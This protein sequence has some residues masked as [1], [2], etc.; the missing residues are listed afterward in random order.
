[1]KRLKVIL[2]LLAILGMQDSLYAEDRLIKVEV[3]AKKKKSEVKDKSD[4]LYRDWRTFDTRT[5][6]EITDFKSV[7]RVEN[8]SSYGCD[9]TRKVESTG[10]F[11]TKKIG[12]RW[13]VVDPDGYA[14]VYTLVN[15]VTIPKGEQS[16]KAFSEKYRS[17]KDW[18]AQTS[19]ILKS[20]GFDGAG[21]WSDTEQI[22]EYNKSA[23][24]PLAYCVT[25]RLMAGYGKKRGGTYQLPGNI[26]YPNQCIFVFDPEFEEYCNEQ[27]AELVKYKDDKNLFGYFSDN[28]LPISRNNLEGYLKL[29]NPNDPGRLAAE[30]YLRNKGIKKEQVTPEHG[31]EF[32]GIVADKYYSIVSSAIKK[33]DPNHMYIGSRLH[34]SAPHTESIV[35]AAGNYVDII[36]INYYGQWALTTKH[37][38]NWLNWASNTPFMITEF[39]TKGMDS[40]L[41]NQS[42]A[43]WIVRTQAD[44]GNAYQHFCLAL[45]EAKN[46]VGWHWFKYADNDPTVKGVD[47]SNIDGNK[48]IINNDMEYYEPLVH[49]M[50]QL[51]VNRYALIEYFDKKE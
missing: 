10:F 34:G 41:S 47:P 14:G 2:F 20:F 16:K 19:N 1:M 38:N 29:D 36:S 26:G 37:R 28:E 22:I 46:C 51:N 32:A 17:K 4:D 8:L 18:I 42:G 40:G 35:R 49:R 50:K 11:H 33:Y 48:G 27:V 44:R 13:W 39:Y 21:C 31:E 5:V 15:S 25:L 30:K 3:R 12:D 7:E 9:K 43:G 24:S 6:S 45:L 23:D